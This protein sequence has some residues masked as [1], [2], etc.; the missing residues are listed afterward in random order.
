MAKGCGAEIEQ[1][2]HSA[3]AISTVQQPF[4]NSEGSSSEAQRWGQAGLRVPDEAGRM[5]LE[6]FGTSRGH[7]SGYLKL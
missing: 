2:V 6:G 1:E 4:H 5:H 7:V 3:S